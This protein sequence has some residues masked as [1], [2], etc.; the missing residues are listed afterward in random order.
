MDNFNPLPW[1]EQ[2]SPTLSYDDDEPGLE[3]AVRNLSV[4]SD[5]TIESLLDESPTPPQSPGLHLAPPPRFFLSDSNDD[6]EEILLKDPMA[7]PTKVP[8]FSFAPCD[9]SNASTPVARDESGSP[10]MQPLNGTLPRRAS[11]S[12]EGGLAAR[13]AASGKLPNKALLSLRR[14]SFETPNASLGLGVG[15]G[16]AGFEG[17]DISPGPEP[18]TN[19]AF[20]L[21]LEQEASMGECS[22][23]DRGTGPFVPKPQVLVAPWTST[24]AKRERLPR[25]PG[26]IPLHDYFSSRPTRASQGRPTGSSSP[27][28][29]SP[30][31]DRSS[32]FSSPVMRSSA[33][34]A[35]TGVLTP[36]TPSHMP[37]APAIGGDAPVFDYF[38]YTCPESPM[39][40]PK[41][42]SNRHSYFLPTPDSDAQSA[43]TLSP[44]TQ[45]RRLPASPLGMGMFVPQSNNVFFG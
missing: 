12:D 17:M 44:S 11:A 20:R 36:L 42:A 32:N 27:M 25:S 10:S 5:G 43:T 23:T 26:I 28:L 13:R 15:P 40:S 21:S 38:N 7:T 8:P 41:D 24:A 14:M 29:G 31:R 4:S 39:H 30:T 22:P 45:A 37:N 9:T 18:S 34:A 2:D 19:M 35:N 3:G 33:F 1:T 16:S 6:G